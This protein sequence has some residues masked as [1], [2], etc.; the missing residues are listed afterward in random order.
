[1]DDIIYCDSLVAEVTA[2]C[3]AYAG[4]SVFM[5]DIL[6]ASDEGHR[7]AAFDVPAEF[8]GQ[9]LGEFFARLRRDHHLPVGVITPPPETP[10]APAGLWIAQINPDEGLKITLPMKAVCIMKN[11]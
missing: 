9:T 3:A 1:V 4:I 6:C 11:L 5:R 8:D 2:T 7:F 10:K